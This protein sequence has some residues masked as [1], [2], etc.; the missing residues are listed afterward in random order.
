MKE[1]TEGLVHLYCGDGKGKTTAAV[2]LAVR[3]VGAGKHVVLTQ[4]FKNGNSSEIKAL[5]AL[6][7]MTLLHCKTPHGR[8]SKM[9]D[10]EKLQAKADY[11]ALLEEVLCA[12]QDA[13][14]L[15]LDEAVSACNYDTIREERVIRFLEEKPETLEVVITGRNPSEALLSC[16]DY[17]TEMKKLRHPYERGV[18]ARYGIEF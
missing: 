17:I 13:D 15:I 12:A 14:L 6:P 10:A 4:F 16:A 11:T 18:K 7:H 1:R 5:A 9:S 3:A 2:G 8:Y